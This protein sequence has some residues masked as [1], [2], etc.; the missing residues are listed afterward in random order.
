MVQAGSR[1]LSEIT[2]EDVCEILADEPETR[3]AVIRHLAKDY[4]VEFL[5]H[6]KIATNLDPADPTQIKP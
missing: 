5:S 2:F 6:V 3:A 1:K 4:E